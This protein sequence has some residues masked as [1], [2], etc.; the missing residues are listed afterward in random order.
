MGR[1][2]AL[3]AARQWRRAAALA[4]T[5]V[6]SDSSLFALEYQGYAHAMVGDTAFARRQLSRIAARDRAVNHST[7]LDARAAI[8]AA[9][10][11]KSAALPLLSEADESGPRIDL[12]HFMPIALYD[13]LHGYP[14]F[15]ALIKA[16]R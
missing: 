14:P 8:L 10:G 7:V 3:L 4:D 12:Y 13:I 16:I 5:L 9:L 6:Q 2:F 11:N 15:D 1:L